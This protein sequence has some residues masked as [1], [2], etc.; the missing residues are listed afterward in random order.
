L[1]L[2]AVCD[3]RPNRKWDGLAAHLPARGINVQRKHR[4]DDLRSLGW[5]YFTRHSCRESASVD[6]ESRLQKGSAPCD[7]KLEFP[8][9]CAHFHWHIG[10]DTSLVDE[11]EGSTKLLPTA[12]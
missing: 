6:V 11:G 7:A 9:A 5:H 1:E 12:H 10:V 2:E 4:G 3:A 8:L